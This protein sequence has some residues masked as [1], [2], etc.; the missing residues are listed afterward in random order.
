MKSLLWSVAILFS[1]M[2]AT[3]MALASYCFDEDMCT[4]YNTSLM[5]MVAVIFVQDNATVP[6]ET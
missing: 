5:N 3:M 6:L 1:S 4:E 2:A